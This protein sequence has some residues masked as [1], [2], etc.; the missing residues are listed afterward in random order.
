MTSSWEN[1]KLRALRKCKSGN[2][3]ELKHILDKNS[4]I[5]FCDLLYE[6]NGDSILHIAAATCSTADLRYILCKFPNCANWKNKDD[7]TPLHEAAQ[8]A[9]YDNAKALIE[10]SAEVNALKRADWTPLMLACAKTHDE[11]SCDTV[12][13]LLEHGAL[14]NCV[15]K[16]GWSALHLTC[17]DGN[18]DILNLL[19]RNGADVHKLTN[20]GRS[21]L[22]IACLHGHLKIVGALLNLDNSIINLRDSCGNT[23][24]HEAVLGA[25]V[26]VCR[27]LVERGGE[28][29]SR[30]V[31]C[32]ELLH[33]AASVGS[34]EVIGFLV[35]T[36]K[37]DVNASTDKGLTPLHCAARKKHK[38]AF[39]LLVDL[40]ADVNAPDLFDRTAL[41]YL[42]M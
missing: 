26:N 9:R 37:C 28:V 21:A 6:K 1:E 38:D 11:A 16:D 35:G 14:P 42:C 30:N 20:N 33:L 17:R 22:H 24:L 10:S 15:N 18:V 13:L 31:A 41:D 25:H 12:N 3:D 40:G 23:A 5:N 32:Y 4:S 7:K 8:S 29:L 36:L 27:L 39:G 19:L 34:T 2:L